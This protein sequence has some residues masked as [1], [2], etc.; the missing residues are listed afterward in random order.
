MQKCK[1]IFPILFQ[2][3]NLCAIFIVAHIPILE[4]STYDVYIQLDDDNKASIADSYLRNTYFKLAY[5]NES[6]TDTQL[7]VRVIFMALSALF[8]LL[9]LCKVCRLP[10]QLPQTSDQR[11]LVWISIACVFFNDPTYAV[12]IYKPT[13]YTYIISQLWLAIFFALLLQYWLRAV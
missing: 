10:K 1:V 7:A 3:S 11:Q 13:F 9:Y 2:D 8:C 12:N 6:F 5:I 4:Y